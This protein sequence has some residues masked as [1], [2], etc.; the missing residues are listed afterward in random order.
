[1]AEQSTL[2]GTE[3]WIYTVNSVTG[4]VVKI[5]RVDK[6]SGQRQ[7]LSAEEYAAL[8]QDLTP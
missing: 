6:A 4:V 3:E 7:E 1:M 5:E 2:A 8:Y